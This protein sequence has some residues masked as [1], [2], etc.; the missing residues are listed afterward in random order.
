VQNKNPKRN[1][2]D[3]KTIMHRLVRGLFGWNNNAGNNNA[4]NNKPPK[5][6]GSK[7]IFTLI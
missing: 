5:L 3:D 2:L 4:S 6:F 1:K 7:I